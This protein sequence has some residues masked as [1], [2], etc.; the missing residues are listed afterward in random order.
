VTFCAGP[1]LTCRAASA[2]AFFARQRRIRSAPVIAGALAA[3]S[4]GDD[5]RHDD[6]TM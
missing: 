5:R 2:A 6:V 1:S 3:L 4:T